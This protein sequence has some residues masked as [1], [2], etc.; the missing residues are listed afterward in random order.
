[1]NKT[2]KYPIS[3][4]RFRLTVPGVDGEALFKEVSGIRDSVNEAVSDGKCSGMLPNSVPPAFG[5]HGSFSLREGYVIG[6]EMKM[7]ID[8]CVGGGNT[9]VIRRLVEID[10]IDERSENSIGWNLIRAWVI[11]YTGNSLKNDDDK[12]SVG[13]MEITYEGITSGGEKK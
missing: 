9:F 1:M 2:T 13:S 5:G 12:C 10:L 4:M 7:W 6:Q 11:K 8:N 3:N